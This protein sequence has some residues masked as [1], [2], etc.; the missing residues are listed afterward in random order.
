M[1]PA[2]VEELGMILFADLLEHGVGGNALGGVYDRLGQRRLVFDIDGT[3][4]A[5]RQRAL[6]QG[7][8]HPPPRRRLGQ[9]CAPGYRGRKRGEVVRNRSIVQQ[10]HSH[11]WLGLFAAPGNGELL[12]ELSKC[13]ERI[14]AYMRH[15]QLEP[16]QA[17][18]RVDGAY[19]RSASAQ[20]L[21]E[22]GMDFVLRC[23][24]YGLLDL[25]RC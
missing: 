5:G 10:A 4:Q 23:T 13:S 6:V 21:G 14:G 9:S 2:A 7:P 15:H 16:T 12:T 18:V 25:Q 17:I 8:E 3:R 24:D 11:E 20:M 1:P 19:G 22:A